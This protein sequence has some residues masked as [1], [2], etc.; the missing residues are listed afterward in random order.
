MDVD[1]ARLEH[2]R[3]ATLRSYRVPTFLSELVGGIFNYP[4]FDY[5]CVLTFYTTQPHL[6]LQLIYR[7]GSTTQYCSQSSMSS[8]VL[9]K[10]SRSSES[11][12]I[13]EKSNHPEGAGSVAADTAAVQ[14]EDVPVEVVGANSLLVDSAKDTND[15]E[16]D[17]DDDEIGPTLDTGATDDG[18]ANKRR[19]KRTG[20]PYLL[21]LMNNFTSSY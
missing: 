15:D 12:P 16:D 18:N 2:A 1:L 21:Q 11:P 14:P 13:S 8:T 20:K 10:R 9:G 5:G 17:D 3:N 19:K 4:T 6:L 7:A